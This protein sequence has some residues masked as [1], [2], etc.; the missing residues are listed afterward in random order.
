MHLAHGKNILMNDL[1]IVRIKVLVL[2]KYLNSPEYYE[3]L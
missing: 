1:G 3:N 2:C